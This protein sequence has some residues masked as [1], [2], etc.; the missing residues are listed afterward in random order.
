VRRCRYG[1]IRDAAVFR[2]AGSAIQRQ[3]Q[4]E[5]R[6]C[7]Q[8][9]QSFRE[10]GTVS[11]V[12]GSEKIYAAQRGGEVRRSGARVRWRPAPAEA[13]AV[14]HA[15]EKKPACSVARRRTRRKEAKWQKS[16]RP[17]FFFFFSA[18]SVRQHS[19]KER[20]ASMRYLSQPCYALMRAEL[21]CY[22]SSDDAT[23]CL[24]A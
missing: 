19:E 8:Q 7:A 13:C 22:A 10:C 18:R 23:L 15:G 21:C 17:V 1:A 14:R 3:V 16:L 5:M 6:E 4:K 11:G 9:V 2:K 24:S 12:S 20:G